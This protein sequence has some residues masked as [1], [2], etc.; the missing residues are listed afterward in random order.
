MKFT[1]LT[2]AMAPAEGGFA[3]TI[4]ENWL[5]G[6]TTYGG[7]SAALCLEGALR[8]FPDLPPLRSAQI[9]YVGPV[10]GPIVVKS[11][12]LRRGKNVAF[13]NADLFSGTGLAT[14][15]VFA[16]G[17][18]RAPAVEATFLP[19][20]D[21]PPPEDVRAP[22]PERLP[23]FARNFDMRYLTGGRPF[24]G[25]R[26][27]DIFLWLRHGDEN[28]TTL[29]AL[30]ALADMPPP[31]ILPLMPNA[32]P[33]STINWA[34]NFLSDDPLDNGWKLMETRAESASAG[35]SSQDMFL[36]RRDGAPL[37]AARQCV[38]VFL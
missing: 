35:Y 28:A 26:D 20:R 11:E 16:F 3:A 22:K 9:S 13:V 7:L 32:G 6:R 37:I 33:I 15:A 24:S 27:C 5:Q 25:S 36:W 34:L 31:A 10:G 30:L 21:F 23:V 2:A 8:T 17:S 29:P 14:R 1:E 12:M 4:S 38:A 18:E 19:M